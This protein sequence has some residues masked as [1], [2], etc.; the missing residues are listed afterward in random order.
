MC[1][2]IMQ[3]M[4]IIKPFVLLKRAS[5]SELGIVILPKGKSRVGLKVRKPIWG[6]LI[7]FIRE[8]VSILVRENLREI[9]S[10]LNLFDKRVSFV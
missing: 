10:L 4:V 8:F 3:M 9:D 6:L 5:F 2:I 7:E 1:V